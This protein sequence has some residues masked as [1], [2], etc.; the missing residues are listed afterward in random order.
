M[1]E[2]RKGRP[3]YEHRSQSEAATERAAPEPLDFQGTRA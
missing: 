3:S 2:L 1:D